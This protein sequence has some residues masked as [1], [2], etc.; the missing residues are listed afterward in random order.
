M[1]KDGDPHD[2]AASYNP[3]TG[4][5]DPSILSQAGSVEI[6]VDSTRY[7]L[8][9][10]FVRTGHP[11]GEK[12]LRRYAGQDV[13]NRFYSTHPKSAHQLLARFAAGK[14][15][16]RPPPSAA[17]QAFKQLRLRFAAELF[18]EAPTAFLFRKVGGTLAVLGLGVLLGFYFRLWLASALVLALFFE[19]IGTCSHDIGHLPLR[20]RR[21][22]GLHLVPTL[23]LGTSCSFWM[24]R[25]W[26]HHN[27]PNHEAF[28][29]D[30]TIYPMAWFTESQATQFLGGEWCSSVVSRRLA[31]LAISVQAWLFHGWLILLRPSYLVQGFCS[32]DAEER[33][34]LLG[35]ALLFWVLPALCAPRWYTPLAHGLGGIVSGL[36]LM[37]NHFHLPFVETGEEAEAIA[38]CRAGEVAESFYTEQIMHTGGFFDHEHSSSS[39][40][41]ATTTAQKL[42]H[43][44]LALWHR[45]LAAYYG[46]LEYH[47]EHHLFPRAP[48]DVLAKIS[49]SVQR[50]CAEHGLPYHRELGLGEIHV[51]VLRLLSGV[52]RIVLLR[53]DV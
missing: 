23:L 47:I 9:L 49:P 36:V 43:H 37:A 51:E 25:H 20:S 45:L 2:A 42:W 15:G 39:R 31:A 17:E 18:T 6:V 21:C 44:L 8:P 52:S 10:S 38:A 14:A 50:I 16:A 27:S 12:M 4:W 30:M 24:T 33:L 29:P 3:I 1:G 28:D 19:M 41:A 13:S 35:H 11:G 5:H 26:E 32:G 53:G 40:P 7:V 34:A 46:G 22:G 48:A